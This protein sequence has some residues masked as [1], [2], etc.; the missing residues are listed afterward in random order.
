MAIHKWSWDKRKEKKVEL[1]SFVIFG[2]D[3]IF[4]GKVEELV[5][6]EAS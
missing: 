2:R 1:G 3:L 4:A 6:R 5:F